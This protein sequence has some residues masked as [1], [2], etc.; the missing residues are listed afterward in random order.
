MRKDVRY[1]ALTNYGRHR[2]Y[3]DNDESAVRLFKHYQSRKE[4]EGSKI[5]YYKLIKETRTDLFT[6][7]DLAEAFR[8]V[9]P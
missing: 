1:Y 8:V 5:V 4:A 2:I 7:A 9:E 6:H 3:V